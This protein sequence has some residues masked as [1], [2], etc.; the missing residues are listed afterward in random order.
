[1]T[2][3]IWTTKDGKQI[4]VKEMTTQHIKNCIN[5]LKRNGFISHSTLACYLTDPGPLGDMAQLQFEREQDVVFE[6]PVTYMLDVFEKE[7]KEREKNV[8]SH[9]GNSVGKTSV[10]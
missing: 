8:T 2:E 4:P 9:N 7:L 10:E 5:M 6:A 1:M 3:H